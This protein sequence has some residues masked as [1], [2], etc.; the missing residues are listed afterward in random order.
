MFPLFQSVRTYKIV[1]ST[2]VEINY[3]WKLASQNQVLIWR[4]NERIY[5]RIPWETRD[6][7]SSYCCNMPSEKKQSSLTLMGLTSGPEKKSGTP[8]ELSIKS[9]RLPI[10]IQ[11]LGKKIPMV[12]VSIVH[13][14]RIS[15]KGAWSL[16]KSPQTIL[17]LWE[18]G[19]G[20]YP[21]ALL[22][23][24]LLCR[25]V[26]LQTEKTV[27]WR[28]NFQYFSLP[29]FTK[30]QIFFSA[31]LSHWSIDKVMMVEMSIICAILAPE[32]YHLHCLPEE[33]KYLFKR[34]KTPGF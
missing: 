21:W 19:S 9:Q 16:Q 15:Y 22:K 10:L 18:F 5:F 24:E 3:H 20:R 31:C 8:E 23:Y 33:S 11:R 32:P 29:F 25:Y 14:Q 12:N 26:C 13:Q 2:K 28:Q 6:D 34:L 4:R 1:R 17:S 7:R 27:L 30:K